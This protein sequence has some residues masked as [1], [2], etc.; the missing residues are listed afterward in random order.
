MSCADGGIA[1]ILGVAGA[2]AI[3]SLVRSVGAEWSARRLLRAGWRRLAAIPRRQTQQDELELIEL[4]LDRIG[5]LVPRLAAV[6]A[7]NEVA[8]VAALTDVR[9][10]ANMVNL[11]HDRDALSPPARVAVNKVLLG[12]ATHFAVQAALGHVRKPSATLLRYIDRALDAVIA[13]D[14]AQA[15]RVLQQLVGIR[16]GLFA[17]AAP[18]RPTPQPGDAAPVAAAERLA[19]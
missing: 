2:A 10:G 4:L 15:P 7:G 18:Y 8:A 14:S 3:T 5:L 16:R 12:T 6:G 13:L 9:I 17:D 11:Q 1:A 19:A